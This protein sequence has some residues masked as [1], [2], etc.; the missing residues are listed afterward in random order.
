M[1]L[2]LPMRNLASAFAS[3]CLLVAC[4]FAILATSGIAADLV[5]DAHIDHVTV[6]REGAVVNR[7]AEVTVPA[8]SHRL[9]FRGLP[10]DVDASTL[11]V[12]VGDAAVQL[13]G[14]EVVAINE[15]NFVSEPERELRR[16]IEEVGDQEAVLKDEVATA[17]NQ[18]K[19]LDSLASDPA[20]SPNKAVVDAAAPDDGFDLRG[21]VH[22]LV[23]VEGVEGEVLGMGLHS[24][25][26]VSSCGAMGAWEISTLYT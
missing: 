23:A 13:G 11:Q 22:H 18:L 6:Y 17:Q 4:A 20:G 9:I 12:N 25:H 21:E 1:A 5:A 10:A 19:L 24:G 3:R 15:A 7:V 14:I 2:T 16:R 8:G 26:A